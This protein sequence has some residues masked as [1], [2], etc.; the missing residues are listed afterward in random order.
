MTW[1][2]FTLPFTRTH[3]LCAFQRITNICVLLNLTNHSKFHLLKHSRCYSCK[4]R[5]LRS[6]F[7]FSISQ[8]FQSSLTMKKKSITGWRGTI[9]EKSGKRKKRQTLSE[10]LSDSVHASHGRADKLL[11]TPL[12]CRSGVSIK[13][14]QETKGQ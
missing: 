10:Y 2:S 9:C 11:Q 13:T 1:I 7:V 4:V 14:R 6:T 3:F 5:H 12:C 8:W